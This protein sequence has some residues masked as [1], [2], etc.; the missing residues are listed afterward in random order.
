MRR[1]R[2]RGSAPRTLLW[3]GLLAAALSGCSAEH[4]A[5]KGQAALDSHD[6]S[7]AEARFRRSLE[8]DPEYLPALA[9]L[10]WT[11]HLA[12]QRGAAEAAFTRCLELDPAHASCLRGQASVALAEGELPRARSLIEKAELASPGDPEVAASRALL[13]LVSGDYEEAE[14]IYAGLLLASPQRGELAAG[15]AEARLRKGDAEGAL[16]AVEQGLADEDM[17]VRHRVRL[18]LMQARA[19]VAATSGR[20]DPDDCARTAPPV[21]AW[22]DRAEQAVARAESLGID[23]PDAPAVRRLVLRRRGVVE[24]LCPGVVAAGDPTVSSPP[25]DVGN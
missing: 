19:L 9:G 11:Y 12:S 17:P 8:R 23:S 5:D 14:T 21:L 3:A 10:G 24:D 7:E 15:L 18:W 22:L 20:E 4:Q 13:A 16:Q 25:Q 1:L 2:S 6:L